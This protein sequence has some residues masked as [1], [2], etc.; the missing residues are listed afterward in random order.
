MPTGRGPAVSSPIE[1][2]QHVVDDK[3]ARGF[4]EVQQWRDV[5]GADQEQQPVAGLAAAQ[6]VRVDADVAVVPVAGHVGAGVVAAVDQPRKHREVVAQ[7]GFPR[8]A[9]GGGE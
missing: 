4:E 7:A 8:V 6:D 2:G 9:I 5:S 3:L 1:V